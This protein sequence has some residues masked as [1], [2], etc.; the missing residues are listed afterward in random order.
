MKANILSLVLIVVALCVFLPRYL[1]EPWPPLRIAGAMIALTS[2]SL[3]VLARLQLGRSFSV[4]AKATRLVTTG[5]Y[6]RIR[7]PIYTSGCFFFLGLAMFIPAW[8]LLLALVSVIPM[9]VV[10]SR[11]EAAVLEA[12]FGDEYRRYRQQTWF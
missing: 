11:R 7:N 2:L 10:R 8:W 5:L 4:R 3:I 9:Q 1:H 6:S 12:T